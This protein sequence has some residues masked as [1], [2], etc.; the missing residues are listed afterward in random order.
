MIWRWIP[1]SNLQPTDY[2]YYTKEGKNCIL[3]WHWGKKKAPVVKLSTK[4]YLYKY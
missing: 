1:V 3:N 4:Y 2:K